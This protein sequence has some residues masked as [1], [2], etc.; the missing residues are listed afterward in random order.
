V[1]I[2][3]GGVKGDGGGAGG[4][5]PGGKGGA[6]CGTGCGVF[7]IK[8]LAARV[9]FAFTLSCPPTPAVAPA[10][11][12]LAAIA[13]HIRGRKGAGERRAGHAGPAGHCART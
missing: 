10:S 11:P 13:R 1:R 7:G 5:G 3:A 8:G 12:S 4:T 9:Y 6:H 2:G